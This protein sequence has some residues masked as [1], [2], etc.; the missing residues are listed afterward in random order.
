MI[1]LIKI[2][3]SRLKEQYGAKEVILFGSYARGTATAD[4]DIDMLV[5]SESK[6][7]FYER[8]ASVKRLL[9]DLIKR[10]PFSPIVLTHK[11]LEYRKK[12]GDQFINEILETGIRT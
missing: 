3:A 1:D 11:E 4:S 10:I 8:Q 2:I 9:R 7:R 12:I 5:I 6:E